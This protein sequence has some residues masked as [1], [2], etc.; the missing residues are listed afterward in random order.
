MHSPIRVPTRGALRPRTVG[1]LIFGLVCAALLFGFAKSALAQDPI[2]DQATPTLGIITETATPPDS[3][4]TPI[5]TDTETPSPT[6]EIGLPTDA[7]TV[8]PSEVPT[9]APTAIPTETDLPSPSDTPPPVPTETA[10]PT[11]VP[12]DV[13]TDIPT[14]S[15][16]PTLE[17]TLETTATPT[18]IS[19]STPTSSPTLEETATPVSTETPVASPTTQVIPTLEPGIAQGKIHLQGNPSGADITLASDSGARVLL[20]ASHSFQ[21]TLPPGTY[22]LTASRRG[23]LSAQ[24]TTLIES[25]QT[26]RLPALTL[27]AG[28]ANGDGVVDIADAALV[29]SNFDRTDAGDADLNGDGQVNV[30]DLVLVNTNFGKQGIQDW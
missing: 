22:V 7:P 28:D 9:D 29:A 23:Y 24:H 10:A 8:Q 5:A 15:P 6:D 18:D 19:I 3:T 17:P 27:R 13:P 4:A 26:V 1:N 2:G 30:L 20:D 25:N 11:A 14:A 12:T 16:I 21:L